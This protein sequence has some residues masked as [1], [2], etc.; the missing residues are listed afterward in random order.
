[1]PVYHF[2]DQELLKLT[3]LE[4]ISD[5]DWDPSYLDSP[6]SVGNK[7]YYDIQSEIAYFDPIFD[8]H[9]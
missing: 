2:T 3:H 6:G 5:V 7:F 8:C 9:E 1:M 4:L